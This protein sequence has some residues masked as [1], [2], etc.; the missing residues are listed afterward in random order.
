MPGF[1]L[2]LL[3]LPSPA[4]NVPSTP[5]AATIL[6]LLDDSAN[7]PGWRWSSGSTPGSISQSSVG[8]TESS[9]A[10][11]SS[12]TTK[13]PAADPSAFLEAIKRS[14]TALINEEP[15]I[16]RMD[17]IAGDGDCGLTLKAGATGTSCSKIP[18]K[19]CFQQLSMQ[20]S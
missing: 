16:T 18:S 8:K 19:R 20:L 3:L 4:D 9:A 12:E 17:N 7:T 13:I 1:S 5:E 10:V 2:T 11:P 14:C 6:S 15:E